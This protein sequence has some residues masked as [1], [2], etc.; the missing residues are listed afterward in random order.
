MALI[1]KKTPEQKA[2][3]AGIKEQKREVEQQQRER[4]E[5]E[6]QVRERSQRR[7]QVRNAF[8]AT[9][10]GQARLAFE[11]D[12]HVFQYS[13]DA[14]KTADPVATLNSVC[15]EGWELVSGSFVF[16][17]EGQQSRDKV[18]SSGQNIATMGTTVGF[19]L[20][21]RREANRGETPEPWEEL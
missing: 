21:R 3:E 9:P 19:Y 6:Q 15:N 17:E 1:S 16:V 2:I 5:A 10:A 12:D 4:A 7:E 13:I 18:G 11:R 14:M 20:F 8:F